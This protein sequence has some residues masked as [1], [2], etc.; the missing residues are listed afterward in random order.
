MTK[1]IF[2][3]YIFFSEFLSDHSVI[4]KNTLGKKIRKFNIDRLHFTIDEISDDFINSI[5]IANDLAKKK[6][7]LIFIFFCNPRL[8]QEKIQL[9]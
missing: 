2:H 6:I 4:Y 9:G 7:G 1:I 5:K 8:L 3:L